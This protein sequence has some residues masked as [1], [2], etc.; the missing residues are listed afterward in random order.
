[1]RRLTHSL[2]LRMPPR[3]ALL[4]LI[5]AHLLAPRGIA[6]THSVQPGETLSTIATQYGIDADTLARANQLGDADLVIIG[7]KLSVPASAAPFIEYRVRKGDSLGSIATRFGV[8]PQEISKAND[9]RNDDLVYTGE[10]LRIPTKNSRPVTYTVRKGDSLAS[11]AANQG[12]SAQSIAS[13]NK[14]RNADLLQVGQILAIPGGKSNPPEPAVTS[15]TA[16]IIDSPTITY[17][18]QKGDI[19]ADIAAAQGVPASV[20]ADANELQDA[21]L[22]QVGQVLAIPGGKGNPPEPVATKST[23]PASDSP[24]ATYTVQKGDVLAEIAADQGVPASVIAETNE[25]HDVNLLKVGQVLIIPDGTS[26]SADQT[27]KGTP[28]I[29][30][31][32]YSVQKGDNLESI[33]ARH[34]VSVSELIRGNNIKNADLVSVGQRLTIPTST[35]RLTAYT[36]RKGETLGTIAAH[37][38]LSVSDI[39][40][41][42]KLSRPDRIVAGQVLLL[43]IDAVTPPPAPAP[44]YPMMPSSTRRALDRVAVKPGQWE[45]IV[46]HHSGTSLGSGKNIDRY[47][48]EERHM[49]NGLAYHFVIGNGNGMKDGEIYIGGRWKKQIEG[50]HLAVHSLNLNSIG[51]CLI[52]NFEK[53]R[54][55]ARQLNSLEALIRYLQK[56]TG[57]STDAVTTHKLIHPKHTLCPGRRFPAEAFN[58]RLKK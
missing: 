35:T 12:V 22:L 30:S 5:A 46:I 55:S 39:L 25:L 50:G 10:Q 29:A 15:S 40:A 52:G 24:A 31:T 53:E 57:L 49:E 11:I 23:A 54:P 28:K 6:L 26:S 33:A 51:I 2:S 21:N 38:R 18:V 20:I 56:A 27:G 3:W 17:T 43:P 34:G 36:V 45:H 48:R 14:L 7:Q 1:M 32:T 4:A 16:P 19:L 42:N 41:H 44:S 13:A 58:V 8:S 9:L 47:H 37:H